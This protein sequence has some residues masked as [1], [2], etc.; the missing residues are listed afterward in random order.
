MT[1]KSTRSFINTSRTRTL[2]IPVPLSAWKKCSSQRSMTNT[3][4]C[5]DEADNPT[6]AAGFDIAHFLAA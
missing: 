3:E 6:R 5:D 4:H 1:T 2:L